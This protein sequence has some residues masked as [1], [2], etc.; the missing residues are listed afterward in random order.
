[1]TTTEWKEHD[2]LE[3]A[4][5]RSVYRQAKAAWLARGSD[6]NID[7]F[8]AAERRLEAVKASI[9]KGAA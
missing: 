6:R 1:M 7:A 4:Y 9:A 5:A 2:R 8:F 3:L